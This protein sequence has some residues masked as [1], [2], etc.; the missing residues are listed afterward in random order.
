MNEFNSDLNGISKIL[1]PSSGRDTTES[2]MVQ[3][4]SP[5]EMTGDEP[6]VVEMMDEDDDDDD[7]DDDEDEDDE[8]RSV[9]NSDHD[10]QITEL[11]IKSNLYFHNR[12]D[13]NNDNENVSSSHRTSRHVS[14]DHELAGES[15]I[16]GE[17]EEIVHA[18]IEN[19]E[20]VESEDRKR[21]QIELEFVQSLANPNYLNFLAQRGYFKNETFIN[22]LKY[23]MYWKKP[24]YCKHLMYPQCLSLL[25]ML[26]HEKFLKEIVNAACSKYI[27]EQIL[28][29]WLH[30]K[31]RRD[32]IRIDPTKL[33]EN[34]EKLFHVE[35]KLTNKDDLDDEGY[36]GE[37]RIKKSKEILNENDNDN[38]NRNNNDGETANLRHHLNSTTNSN[39]PF[40]ASL[41]IANEKF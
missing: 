26:Q 13:S 27:D 28:L 10:D 20:D 7:D 33:P 35:T 2:D 5:I 38:D 8:Y 24:E 12:H 15:L 31:T 17:E 1:R 36:C 25:E 32:W 41:F 30:Y 6:D 22:Y 21:F 9:H 3:Q 16:R 40:L 29:I 34:I 18:Q 39:D 4:Q 37:D 14:I 23:L 11:K 19:D